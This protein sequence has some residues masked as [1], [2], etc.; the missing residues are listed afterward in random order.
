MLMNER[1]IKE[2][3]T[4]YYEI[5]PN[6]REVLLAIVKRSGGVYRDSFLCSEVINAIKT[7]KNG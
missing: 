1:E 4:E 5:G 6:L 7:Q 2:Q 3:A